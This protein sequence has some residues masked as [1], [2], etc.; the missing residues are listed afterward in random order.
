MN[1]AAPLIRAFFGVSKL[2]IPRLEMAR[3]MRAKDPDYYGVVVEIRGVKWMF[4]N[5]HLD[6]WP[7]H[8]VSA[9]FFVSAWQAQKIVRVAKVRDEVNTKKRIF[10]HKVGYKVTWLAVNSSKSLIN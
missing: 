10:C 9:F 3:K 8:R 2:D 7:R 5:R 4:G 6:G 1:S